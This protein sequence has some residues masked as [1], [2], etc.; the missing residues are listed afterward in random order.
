MKKRF[1]VYSVCWALLLALFNIIVFATPNEIGGV[2][3][4]TGGFWIGYGFTVAAF[5]GQLVCAFFA[6]KQTENKKLF[7]HIPLITISYGALITTLVVGAIFMSIPAIPA[8]IAAVVCSIVLVFSIIAVIKAKSA[9]EVVSGKDEKIAAKTAFIKELTTRA[10]IVMINTATPELK[11]EAKRV[12]EAI[13][14]SD[15]MSNEKLAEVENELSEKFAEFERN[16][17]TT[18]ANETIALVNKRAALCKSIKE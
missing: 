3:K 1:S 15:P 7:Y 14:Y 5:A 16:V 11:V 9:A 10:N 17:N 13:R 4:F 18:A 6:L 2:S 12:Y 8:W